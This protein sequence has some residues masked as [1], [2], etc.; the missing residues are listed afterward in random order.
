MTIA[1]VVD[2]FGVRNGSFVSSGV[3][4]F[5]RAIELNPQVITVSWGIPDLDDANLRSAISQAI[6]AG[7][8]VCC[9]CGNGG[10]VVFPSSMPDVISV[11]GAYADTNDSL[12]S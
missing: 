3:A 2:F 8:T 7:I 4:A 9:A 12:Q 10:D 11:G 6:N 1:L 5:N